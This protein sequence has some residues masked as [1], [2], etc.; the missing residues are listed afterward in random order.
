MTAHPRDRPRSIVTSLF[1]PLSLATSLPA[2]KSQREGNHPGV[3]RPL[4]PSPARPPA[5]SQ[6]YNQSCMSPNDLQKCTVDSATYGVSWR[7][8]VPITSQQN[9]LTHPVL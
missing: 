3:A 8:D 6:L 2:T 5:R 9:P 4:S 1:L 7:V